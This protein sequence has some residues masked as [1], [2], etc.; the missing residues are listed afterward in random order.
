MVLGLKGTVEKINSIEKSVEIER[1]CLRWKV[2]NLG[3]IFLGFTRW[4]CETKK[5]EQ[6]KRSGHKYGG[7]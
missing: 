5:I 3:E 2:K 1:C 6:M 4:A 7:N